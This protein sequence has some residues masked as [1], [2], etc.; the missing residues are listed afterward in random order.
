VAHRLSTIRD[1]DEIILF[2]NARP[3]FE[4]A[5]EIDPTKADPGSLTG[6]IEVSHI[7]FR[8]RADGPAILQ[9]VSFQ[10]RP[11]EFIAI[12]AKPRI[13]LF[14]EATSA[15]D[16]RTQAIVSSSLD[17]LQATRIVIAH[18]LST[19]M[20]AHRIYVMS[21]GRVVQHGTYAE[22]ADQPGP[23]Q[24]LIRRQLV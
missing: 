1:C 20:N 10:A 16:N 14:D 17:R 15:L 9:D 23:F 2:D 5:L 6:G 22:L 21:A 11:G 24:D 13:L 12:V 7:S 19:I 8:Y 18:R 3:I 4:T